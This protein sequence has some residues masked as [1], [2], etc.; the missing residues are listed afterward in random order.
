MARQPQGGRGLGEP[1]VYSGS[2]ATTIL[3]GLC[4]DDASLS[5]HSLLLYARNPPTPEPM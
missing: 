3:L 4:V 2:A 5:L 1:S